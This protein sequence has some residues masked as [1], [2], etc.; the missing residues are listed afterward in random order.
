[1]ATSL[2]KLE[3]PYKEIRL[4]EGS[5]AYVNPTGQAAAV[6]YKHLY[7]QTCWEW[8]GRCKKSGLV[9]GGGVMMS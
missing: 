4:E 7:C 5:G 9:E 1:M 8:K 6:L 3:K 2:I